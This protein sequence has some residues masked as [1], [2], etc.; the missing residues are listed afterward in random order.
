MKTEVIKIDSTEPEPSLV[1]KVADMLKD[2]ALVGLP[3]E[4]V[5]GVAVCADNA[6]ALEK[7]Y[8]IKKRPMDKLFALQVDDLSRIRDC[9]INIPPV[10]EILAIEC[11]PGPLTMIFNGKSGTIGLRIPDNKVTLA[12]LRE[13]A[14]PLAVTSAN[15]S[16]TTAVSCAN[17]ALKIFDDLIDAVVDDGSSA[18]GVEST[19]LDCSVS[20]IKVLRKGVAF[21]K[22][23]RFIKLYG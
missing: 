18:A 14:A 3:T 19:V 12:I 20:P 15:I 16:G 1:T 4:T 11:C 2:G 17:E 5:Y 8:K 9:V 6:I 10:V 7:L 22:L 13:V 21:E 23:E